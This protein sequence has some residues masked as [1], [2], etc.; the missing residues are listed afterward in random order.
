MTLIRKIGEIEVYEIDK[1]LTKF[2]RKE[3]E[4]IVNE[5]FKTQYVGK[6]ISYLLKD[7]EIHAII[8]GVTR[9]NY[10]TKRHGKY[11]AESNNEYNARIDLAASEDYE[12]LIT[13]AK[14][15]HSE[16]DTKV[17]KNNKHKEI[18]QW[19]Y[20]DKQII[21]NNNKYFLKIAIMQKENKYFVYNT[22]LK[23]QK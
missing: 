11:N 20:F 17:V 8:N 18:N 1:D 5:L 22:K 21:F 19:H 10:L 13:N 3:R 14:Y 12:R 7:T 2:T 16:K 4:K 23:E 15:Y 6:E 9:G